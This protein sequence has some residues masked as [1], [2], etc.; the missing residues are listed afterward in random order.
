M[1][2][3]S[4]KRTIAI[5][6]CTCS[7]TIISDTAAAPPLPHTYHGRDYPNDTDYISFLQRFPSYAKSLWRSNYRGDPNLGYFGTGAHDHNQMRSHANFIFVCALLYADENYDSSVSRI[8][9]DWLLTQARAAL[10]FLTDTHVTGDRV[11]VDGRKWGKQPIQWLAPW[12]MSKALA[13]A[14]LIWDELTEVERVSI[15]RMVVQEANYQLKQRALSRVYG[16]S[17]AEFNAINSEVLAWAASLYP[18]HANADAWL[19]KAQEQF[20]NTLSVAQDRQNAAIVDGKPVSEWVYTTNVHPDF[21][22][23]GHGGYQFDYIAVPLHSLAWAYYAFVSNGQ[24]VPQSLFHNL[25]NVW[26]AAK[27]THLYSGRFAY[28]QG[29]DWARHVYGPYFIVPVLVL[30]QNEFGESDARFVE[31]LRFGA[32]QWEQQQNSRGSVFGRRFGY[33]RKG[34]PVIYETDCYAN[35]G[36]AYLLHQY[37]PSI[38]AESAHDFQERVTGNFHSRFCRFLY[39]RNNKVFVSFSWK[40]LTRNYPMAL[41]VPGDD[42]MVE[43]ADANLM[44]TLRVENADMS[45]TTARQKNRLIEDG[46][47]TTGHIQE[48]RLGGT[49]GVDHYVSFTALPR[50]SMAVLIELL[51]AKKTI[52]VAEQSGLSYY[53]PNDIF[54]DGSRLVNWERDNARLRGA[55]GV[56]TSPVV[57]DS[58]WVNIDN[59]LGII[60]VPD[61]GRFQ[62]SA[63]NRS[64]WNGQISERID[65]VPTSVRRIYNRDDVIRAQ[66][67][68]FYSGNARSTRKMARTE[69]Q[70][71]SADESLV[72]A[73][74]FI[75]GRSN[76]LIAANFGR[77]SVDTTIRLQSGERLEVRIPGLSTVILDEVAGSEIVHPKDNGTM[78]LVPAGDFIMGTTHSQLQRILQGR[79]DADFLRTIFAHEQPQHVVYLDS[80]YID[81]YEVT[82]RQFE[83]FVDSTG[84]VT[85]AERQGWGFLWD[86][87]NEWPRPRGAS[88]RAPHGRGSSIE[89]KDNHPVVQVSHNDALAYLKWA[90]KRLPTEAEWE[91]ASRGIDGR[92][93]PWGN[94]WDPSRLNSWEA[95]PHRTTPVGN[96][97]K[98][99]SPYGAYDM[100]GNVWEWVFD[101]YHPTYYRT[102]R[103]WSNPRGPA[104]GKHRVLRGACWLNQKIVTRCAHRD[105]FV[106]V[107]DFRVHLGGF[108]GAVSANRFG[109]ASR[110][111]NL[112]DV[113]SDGAVNLLD[114]MLVASEFG[115]PVP[116]Q[117]T[118]DVN[119]DGLVDVADLTLVASHIVEDDVPTAAPS[120]KMHYS[121]HQLANMRNALDSMEA[122]AD[123]SPGMLIARE[124]L[125]DWLRPIPTIV[126][127]TKLLSNYPN[128]FN[129]E[130][131]IPYQ[132]SADVDV[133]IL[134]YDVSGTLVRLLEIGNKK[135]G[136]YDLKSKAAYWDGKTENGEPVSSGLYFYQLR[137]GE[138]TSVKRMVVIK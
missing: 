13:G 114:F 6:L 26:N 9:R 23:E 34:W 7:L 108:R 55:R 62:F 102:P 85:D 37:G 35:L 38:H 111:R 70:W 30:L 36:L 67:Y 19:L 103:E 45:R 52:R 5:V 79:K 117:S 113:N 72:K 109:G 41:F 51:V 71:L 125:R 87:S 32:F 56:G 12:V 60:S 78:V 22:L 132:L 74:A 126:T 57:M 96:Y 105:N 86:G 10:R 20:M 119:L 107:P 106:T 101:W 118:P 122:L 128:P 14:R 76:R 93:Y 18:T 21:T 120:G 110:F 29:K 33:E 129:P 97:P 46:F 44:G 133:Q 58:S 69:V 68:F 43:W 83:K 15:Q 80:F 65:Y 54:N 11:C 2:K 1:S 98:G 95:G 8:D 116:S 82:N 48:G 75:D 66:A 40:H 121:Q 136:V 100:V 131:W 3:Q 92:L 27:R 73:V 88:W 115:Q 17:H 138:F 77:T 104:T 84:Y 53:L 49:F 91:K 137:A 99:V 31:Q 59:K 4:L 50:N 94:Q 28:P 39:A 63:G 112:E 135:A 134:I 25:L 81:K 89:R 124:F 47:V 130:T 127:A 90:G 24:P 61:N 64:I 123:P 16:D 42:Y